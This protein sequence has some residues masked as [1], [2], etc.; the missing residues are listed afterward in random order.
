[1]FYT[2]EGEANVIDESGEDSEEDGGG[3]N[4][5][6]KSATEGVSQEKNTLKTTEEQ[7]NDDNKDINSDVNINT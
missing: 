2:A 6:N 4:Y 3:W 5:Y 1:M 7:Q